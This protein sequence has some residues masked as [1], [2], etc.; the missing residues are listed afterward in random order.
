MRLC[1]NNLFHSLTVILVVLHGRIVIGQTINL[2][3]S[4]NSAN[5][6]INAP[7]FLS[8]ANQEEVHVTMP[9]S[10]I[11]LRQVQ[12]DNSDIDDMLTL[13]RVRVDKDGVEG[14]FR[15]Y[16]RFNH[17]DFTSSK[18][19]SLA[20]TISVAD[21]KNI[22]SG[23]KATTDSIVA[24]GQVAGISAALKE[25]S[26]SV[27]L[28]SAGL[29]AAGAAGVAV[30]SILGAVGVLQSQ[31]SIN[32]QFLKNELSLINKNLVVIQK[33]IE[34]GFLDLTEF[35]GDIALD[36]LA[37]DLSSIGRALDNYVGAPI[38]LRLSTYEPHFRAV[39]NTPFRTPQ[40][41]F[42]DLYGYVCESCEFAPRKR[43]N[44]LEVSKKQNKLSDITFFSGFAV[45]FLQSMMQAISLHSLCIGKIEGTC[46]DRSVDEIWKNNTRIMHSAMEESINLL[47]TTRNSLRN[48]VS[49][50]QVDDIKKLIVQSD[51]QATANNLKDY[52]IG[53]QPSFNFHVHVFEDRQTFVSFVACKIGESA[54]CVTELRRTGHFYFEDVDGLGIHIRYRSNEI[55]IPAPLVSLPDGQR[56][57]DFYQALAQRFNDM[58]FASE[59]ASVITPAGEKCW[60]LKDDNKMAT[61]GVS[62]LCNGYTWSQN[63]STSHTF[64]CTADEAS[65]LD[66][67]RGNFLVF[68]T[69]PS[70]LSIRSATNSEESFPRFSPFFDNGLPMFEY[71]YGD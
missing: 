31:E 29:G 22:M 28:L 64:Q 47:A 52:F 54:G 19:I 20:S 44:L 37:S 14:P 49:Q 45:F 53:I 21:G 41:I 32:F 55:D 3:R 67:F 9:L 34:N 24:A 43:T 7:D 36:Q 68:R 15:Q 38:D 26:E 17:P 50:L 1:L 69:L 13:C 23:L 65:A 61:C 39:C 57:E 8:N 10:K 42:F 63:D 40:D 30:V 35:I 56:F 70:T 51:L 71:H 62:Y 6:S 4:G 58:G 18:S 46:A 16:V 66:A 2:I 11:T 25:A 27:K 60:T 48:F 33:Q 59:S 5:P 12:E